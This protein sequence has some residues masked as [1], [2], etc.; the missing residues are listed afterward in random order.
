MKFGNLNLE[1][2]AKQRRG[3][4]IDT[5]DKTHSPLF[6][7]FGSLRIQFRWIRIKKGEEKLRAHAYPKSH[8]LVILV[9]GHHEVAI[10]QDTVILK[11]Q[12]DYIYLKANERH[13]WRA[14]KDTLLIAIRWGQH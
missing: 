2:S 9:S 12:G 14:K 8:A 4:V 11:K 1:L 10:G 5:I 7:V 13:S 3:F 6:K